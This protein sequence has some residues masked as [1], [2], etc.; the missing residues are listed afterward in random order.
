MAEVIKKQRLSPML[1]NYIKLFSD[2]AEPKDKN[3]TRIAG[4]Y[5][6][7]VIGDYRD[8]VTMFAQLDERPNF[9]DT[10]LEWLYAS[11]YHVAVRDIRPPEA[12]AILPA[13]NPKLVDT[14][15]GAE[16]FQDIQ[17]NR[18]LGNTA[19]VGRHEGVLKFITDRK[20]VTRA[21]VEAYYRN[22]IRSLISDTV[23][24]EFNK[25]SF[26][27]EA[28]DYNVV[29]VRDQKGQYI[30]N[31]EGYFNG[32][33]Q[34]KTLTATSLEALPSA[35]SKSGDFVPAAIDT[36]K[37][38]AALIPAVYYEKNNLRILGLIK[39]AIVKFYETP[40]QANYDIVKD[41]YNGLRI[42]EMSSPLSRA[43]CLSFENTLKSLHPA[44][45]EKV[46]RD[47]W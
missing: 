20:N 22:G 1:N 30:L 9:V 11:Y 43:E 16:A 17:I 8:S 38:Q 44:L 33:K 18:F 4:D 5:Y 25:V 7:Y 15:L 34:T 40:T 21:E 3:K 45:A 35:M 14:I 28:S 32:N 37:A 29:L 42:M 27:L 47:A 10:E 23:D 12:D 6:K 26:Y 19:A 39:Y 24:E 46:A 36:V 41:A 31:Y 13:N 2:G